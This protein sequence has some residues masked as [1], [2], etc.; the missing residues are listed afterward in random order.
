M[1]SLRVEIARHV[2]KIDDEQIETMVRANNERVKRCSATS[3]A[4]AQ[5]YP[6]RRCAQPAAGD[7]GAYGSGIQLFDRIALRAGGRGLC[8]GGT[9]TGKS[10]LAEYLGAAF[11]ERYGAKVIHTDLSWTGS[12]A[13]GAGMVAGAGGTSTKRHYKGW[14]HGEYVPGSCL[15]IS[16]APTRTR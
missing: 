5:Q 4:G 10:T 15:L 9:G 14:S 2:A 7:A 13:P 6:R 3:D 16:P 11:V 1:K 8:V 12:H